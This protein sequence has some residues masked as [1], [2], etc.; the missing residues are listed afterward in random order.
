M[1]KFR[2]IDNELRDKIPD[3]G[4]KIAI[5]ID[6]L[7]YDYNLVITFEEETKKKQAFLLTGNERVH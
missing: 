7:L 2:G 5:I 6:E 4:V 1:K 3:N